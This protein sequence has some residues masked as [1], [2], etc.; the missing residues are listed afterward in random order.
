MLL[1]TSKACQKTRESHSVTLSGS[2][3]RGGIPWQQT[4]HIKPG[5]A[6]RGAMSVA[7]HQAQLPKFWPYPVLG[8]RPW[9]FV[10]LGTEGSWGASVPSLA[11]FRGTI[12]LLVFEGPWVLFPRCLS[13]CGKL[14]PSSARAQ[15]T[16]WPTGPRTLVPEPGSRG[17]ATHS[18]ETSTG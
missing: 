3:T 16:G 11:A 10:P 9:L 1:T 4:K 18:T 12:A 2:S 5:E 6:T 7:G 8:T 15:S 14:W 13:A 17:G